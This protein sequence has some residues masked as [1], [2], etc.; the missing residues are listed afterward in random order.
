MKACLGTENYGL[1][2]ALSGLHHAIVSAYYSTVSSITRLKK[3][4]RTKA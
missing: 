3:G 2:N 4:V 1:L